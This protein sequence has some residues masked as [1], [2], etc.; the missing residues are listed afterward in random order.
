MATFKS[1][2]NFNSFTVDGRIFNAEV[3]EKAGK[4]WLAVTVITNPVDD[5][6][7]YTVTFNTTNGLMALYQKGFLPNGRQVTVTGHISQISEIFEKDGELHVRKRPNIHLIEA[8][9]PT[10][11]LGPMPN[12]D[13]PE[14]SRVGRKVLRP[15]DA[16]KATPVKQD[17]TPAVTEEKEA[18]PF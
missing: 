10:G 6:E 4:S 17:A 12:A 14:A 11:G 5:S 9:I 18:M 3:V 8:Q 7:G 15:S 1:Y 16:A 2:A 13:K